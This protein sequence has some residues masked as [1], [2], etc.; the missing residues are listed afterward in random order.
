MYAH[1]APS[2]I[3]A[4]MFQGLGFAHQRSVFGAFCKLRVNYINRKPFLPLF[5]TSAC[6]TPTRSIHKQTALHITV[7]DL[8][9]RDSITLVP[10]VTARLHLDSISIQTSLVHTPTLRCNN[11]RPH[12]LTEADHS[13]ELWARLTNSAKYLVAY[14]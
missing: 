11:N 7:P 1:S 5:V 3:D 10:D 12:R 13:D 8:R 6:R 4:S 2:C 14:L 9:S